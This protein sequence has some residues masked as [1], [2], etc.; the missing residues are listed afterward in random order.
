VTPRGGHRHEYKNA[1]N[2]YIEKEFT[3]AHRE[4]LQG[5]V[6]LQF[7]QIVRAISERRRIPQPEVQ[8]LVDRAP[9]VAQAA[10]DA[11]LVDGLLYR[12][13]V[14]EKARAI[15]GT[16]SELR[17]LQSYR[18]KNP[19]PYAKGS[20]IAVIVGSGAVLRGE[21]TSNFLTGDATMGSDTVAAAFRTA[22]EDP[23]VKAIIFRVDCPGGSYVASDTILREATR[24]RQKGKP[25]VVTMGTAAASGGYFVSMNAD[26]II[27][28]PGTMTGSIGV[29]RVKLL[30]REFWNKLGITYGEVATAQNASIWSGLAD[31]SPEEQ[32]K[33]DEWLDRIYVDFTQK[34][35]SGRRLP[36][37]RVQEIAKGRVW[38]G[39]TALQL[40][41]VDELGGWHES[42]AAARALAGLKQT[43][44]LSSSSSQSR[45]G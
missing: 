25:V 14:Y 30:T 5:L 37:E 18:K 7:E 28:Q 34:V 15:A 40:G 12:D 38:L 21:S 27:A 39:E 24:A 23:Q 33:F 41:L 4:S 35:A 9:Y 44:R 1:L 45:K 20:K 16:K 31:F 42:I 3:P 36:L 29:L 19:G 10:L 26:R 8:W 2:T 32:G 22:A 11:R 6:D 17:F 43:R 13:E